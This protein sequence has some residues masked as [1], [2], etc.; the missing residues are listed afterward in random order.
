MGLSHESLEPNCRV[1]YQ[2]KLALLD[3]SNCLRV[4]SNGTILNVHN[5]TYGAVDTQ[6]SKGK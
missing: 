1:Y 2:L 4:A 6:V 3:G 5:I